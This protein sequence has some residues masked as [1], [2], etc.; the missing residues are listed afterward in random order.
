MKTEALTKTLAEIA[1]AFS[2]ATLACSLQAE[3]MLLVDTIAR[4]RL[5]IEVFVLDTGRLHADSLSLLQ[6]IKAAYGIEARVYAPDPAAVAD[7]ERAHGRGADGLA[8][9][10]GHRVNARLQRDHLD[11]LEPEAVCLLREVA[12][13][14]VQ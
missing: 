11:W 14:P 12:A 10:E 3:D 5:P 6:R 4:E 2:P 13:G 7:Y 9:R 1:A 8:E